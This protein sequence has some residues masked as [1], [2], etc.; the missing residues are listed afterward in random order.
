MKKYN[1]DDYAKLVSEKVLEKTKKTKLE[2]LNDTIYCVVGIDSKQPSRYRGMSFIISGKTRNTYA[3]KTLKEFPMACYYEREYAY[4]RNYRHRLNDYYFNKSDNDSLLFDDN[5][6]HIFDQ[7]V[8]YIVCSEIAPQINVHSDYLNQLL[9]IEKITSNIVVKP[10]INMRQFCHVYLDKKSY[11]MLKEFD[12][13]LNYIS[14]KVI[15]IFQENSLLVCVDIN[16]LSP[17]KEICSQTLLLI[18][19]LERKKNLLKN[20]LE[21]EF[22]K[23]DPR[24][25]L[26]LQA[27]EISLSN[28]SEVTSH[29]S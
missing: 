16:S 15:E 17:E 12:D 20:L 22:L 5:D 21:N 11:S 7:I 9:P 23:K 25:Q 6:I 29:L 26:A 14:D 1:S 10:G 28:L 8:K 4:E 18:D 3:G 13:I 2:L 24:A 19:E 27:L